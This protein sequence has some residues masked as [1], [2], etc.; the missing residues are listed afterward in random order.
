MAFFDG[1]VAKV[2]E[3]EQVDTGQRGVNLWRW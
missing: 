3:A 1:H 2:S